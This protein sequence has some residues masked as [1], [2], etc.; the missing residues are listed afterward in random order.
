MIK[1]KQGKNATQRINV[2]VNTEKQK[3]I[4]SKL[5]RLRKK[6]NN[7]QTIKILVEIHKMQVNIYQALNLY[8]NFGEEKYLHLRR[9][10]IMKYNIDSTIFLS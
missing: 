5:K 9:N 4:I 10:L 8:I 6:S 3:L 2:L 7:N 1:T